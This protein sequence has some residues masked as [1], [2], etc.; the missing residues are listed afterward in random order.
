VLRNVNGKLEYNSAKEGQRKMPTDKAHPAYR[1]VK[2]NFLQLVEAER[3]LKALDD[4]MRQLF[5]RDDEV[6]RTYSKLLRAVER[7]MSSAPHETLKKL[8]A[9][10]QMSKR[11]LRLLDEDVTS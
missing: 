7:G 10:R 2:K 3:A 5:E 6:E 11:A 4:L 8:L 1:L 9:R